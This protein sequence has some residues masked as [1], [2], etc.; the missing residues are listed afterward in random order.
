MRIVYN[1]FNAINKFS[2]TSK[3]TT[4]SST[5][6]KKN[7]R[8]KSKWIRNELCKCVCVSAAPLATSISIQENITCNIIMG[9][10]VSFVD[11]THF[12]NDAKRNTV[13]DDDIGLLHFCHK[14]M[15]VFVCVLLFDFDPL[16]KRP[17][18]TSNYHE[19]LPFVVDD[20]HCLLHLSSKCFYIHGTHERYGIFRNVKT[21]FLFQRLLSF[22]LLF[23][24]PLNFIYY[25]DATG[26]S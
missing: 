7:R 17:E 5:K 1:R 9:A 26:T 6:K 12:Q 11:M 19:L 20:A 3:Q 13:V 21:I 24:T 4:H 15:S 10:L 25:I 16:L 2:Y 23:V 18:A 22:L 14:Y 8:S